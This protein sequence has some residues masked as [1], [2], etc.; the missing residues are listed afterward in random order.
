MNIKRVALGIIIII[1][2]AT[3]IGGLFCNGIITL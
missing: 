2:A 1:V 3:I